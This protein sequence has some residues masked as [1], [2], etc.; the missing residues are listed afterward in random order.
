MLVVIIVPWSKI[1][2]I[3]Y[4]QELYIYNHEFLKCFDS[5]VMILHFATAYAYHYWSSFINSDAKHMECLDH[6]F[7]P[8]IS[9]LCELYDLEIESAKQFIKR[10]DIYRYAVYFSIYFF[11][12]LFFLFLLR[13]L[14]LSLKVVDFN[15]FIFVNLPLFV[16]TYISFLCLTLGIVSIFLL[17]FVTCEFLRFRIKTVSQKILSHIN[18]AQ[19]A[20]L[21]KGTYSNQSKYKISEKYIGL[22]V[23]ISN[24]N[25]SNN[26]K[27]IKTIGE[28]VRQFH[29]TNNI[30]DNLISKVYINLLLAA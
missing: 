20:K 23:K 29:D 10:T 2:I 13:C 9:D 21:K 3:L 26:L 7:I 14:F 18:R 27:N 6:L 16:V 8:E 15:Y 28:I 22:K 4:L 25:D 30:F 5:A 12:V 17:Y 11:E 19:E 1:E 24:K